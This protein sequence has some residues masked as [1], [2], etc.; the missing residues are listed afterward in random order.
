MRQL[1]KELTV[2]LNNLRQNGYGGSCYDIVCFSFSPIPPV[3]P[4]I[5]WTSGIASVGGYSGA[6]TRLPS[7]LRMIE[8]QTSGHSELNA[9]ALYGAFC[10]RIG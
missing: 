6:N 1:P 3:S 9:V 5:G 4:A 10:Q 7:F 8:A 2:G